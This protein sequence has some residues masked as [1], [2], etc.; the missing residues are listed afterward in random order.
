M[1][2]AQPSSMNLEDYVQT[3]VL[4]LQQ[5]DPTA[6][7]VS[8]GI[9]QGPDHEY[10]RFEYTTKD[11]GADVHNVVYVSAID[12]GFINAHYGTQAD[13]FAK[14]APKIEPFLST[15]RAR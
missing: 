1:A 3:S 2:D 11:H 10:G 12:D 14:T 9:F 6:Q 5:G 7:I 4:T 15:L 8:D 13:R